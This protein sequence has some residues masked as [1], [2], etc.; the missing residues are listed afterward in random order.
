M[1]EAEIELAQIASSLLNPQYLPDLHHENVAAAI[2]RGAMQ[3]GLVQNHRFVWGPTDKFFSNHRL[4]P[5]IRRTGISIERSLSFRDILKGQQSLRHPLEAILLLQTLYDDWSQVVEALNK[6][7]DLPLLDVQASSATPKRYNR[8]YHA[9]H[10]KQKFQVNFEKYARQY[11]ELR[12]E[13]PDLS[14]T[15]L[16]TLLP[17]F[18][19][20]WLTEV[21]LAEAGVEVPSVH[22][23]GL[24]NR[25]LDEELEQ[26]IHKR[27]RYLRDTGYPRR[28]GQRALMSGFRRPTVFSDTRLAPLLVRARRAIKECEETHRQFKH[29]MKANSSTRN[30]RALS[31]DGL[32][33]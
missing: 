29:R 4:L 23:T 25:Q 21:S 9:N 8:E 12:K 32:P 10:R 24:R 5:L 31:A 17:S 27:A 13:Y 28:I 16:M 6:G 22:K 33:V 30:W 2:A 15:E 26:Y 3:K 14:H 7:T 11:A 19:G 18:A 1:E 20:T